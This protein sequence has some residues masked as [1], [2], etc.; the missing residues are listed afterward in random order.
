M[1]MLEYLKLPL[2]QI[3][4]Q[5]MQK[6]LICL[7]FEN[8]SWFFVRGIKKFKMTNKFTYSWKKWSKKKMKE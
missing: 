3:M 1:F 7:V 4:K 5:M 6:L 8:Y 2:E